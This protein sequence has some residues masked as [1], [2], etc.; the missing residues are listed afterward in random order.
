MR[1][2]PRPAGE[3]VVTGRMWLGI[4]FVGAIMA[5]GTLYALDAALP[6]GLVHGSGSIRHAQTMAFTTLILFQLFNVFNARSDDDSAFRGVFENRWLW[7]AVSV[8]AAL[9]IAVVYT[10]FL[11]RAFST[12]SLTISDWLRCVAIASSVLWLREIDK[13]WRR[14]RRVA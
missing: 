1:Q 7:A 6:G 8:S 12:K 9:Q 2:P 10:P 11:Q 3:P 13:L 5:A 4:F 14:R